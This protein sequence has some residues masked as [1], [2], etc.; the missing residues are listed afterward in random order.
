MK[1]RVEKRREEGHESSTKEGRERGKWREQWKC[2]RVGNSKRE[3]EE[4]EDTLLPSTNIPNM[5]L[6]WL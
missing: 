1:N 5:H 6:P 2:G 4:T 3:K